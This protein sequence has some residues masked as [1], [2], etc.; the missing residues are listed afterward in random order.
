M[1]K[2]EHLERLPILL[3]SFDFNFIWA[4]HVS[5]FVPRT[6][7]VFFFLRLYIS[8]FLSFCLIKKA[9]RSVQSVLWRA[10]A[11]KHT[12]RRNESLYSITQLGISIYDFLLF[13][14][15]T[16]PL[17]SLPLHYLSHM[18]SFYTQASPKLTSYIRRYIHIDTHMHNSQSLINSFDLKSFTAKHDTKS[19]KKKPFFIRDLK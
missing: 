16:F 7:S 17:F 1:S 12:R 8:Y 19:K 4:I 10:H 15:I 18:H 11:H 13:F 3:S 5:P 6:F 2:K 9:I 14:F